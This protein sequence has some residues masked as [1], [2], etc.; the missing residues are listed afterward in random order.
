[1]ATVIGKVLSDDYIS[2]QEGILH[3]EE[4]VDLLP[5]NIE[6]SG[7][8]ISLVNAMSRET[9]L[10]Q[11]AVKTQYDYVLLDCHPFLGMLTINVLAAADSV[12][13]PVQAQYLSLKGLEQLL[14]T[15]AEVRRQINPRLEISGILMAMVDA[16]TNY[17]KDIISLLKEAN[18]G[19]LNIF[20]NHIPLSVRAAETS[21]EGKTLRRNR[22][23]RVR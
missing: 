1:L 12:I 5:A 22:S 19:K 17:A 18:G 7:A 3:H 20:A 10:R 4:G 9:I 15:I 14:Q 6:L 13:I 23:R 8:E 2:P 16:W 21:S 11:Y